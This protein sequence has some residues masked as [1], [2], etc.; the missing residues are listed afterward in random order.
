MGESAECLGGDVM[1]ARATGLAML[2]VA[3]VQEAQDFS[4]IA[5]AAT[6]ES[7]IPFSSYLM[8]SGLRMRSL[9]SRR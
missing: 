7:R 8:N 6:L 1:A 3:S 4:L 9:K 2:S 5:H